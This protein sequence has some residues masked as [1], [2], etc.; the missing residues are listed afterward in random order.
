MASVLASV[1][2]Q[3]VGHGAI[4]PSISSRRHARQPERRA[5]LRAGLAARCA[6]SHPDHRGTVAELRLKWNSME[7]DAMVVSEN[8][9]V[10]QEHPVMRW[11]AVW[12]GWLVATGI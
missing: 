12:A 3:G 2:A 11:G 1:P 10:T 9:V 5:R 8:A 7:D 4:P 6:H